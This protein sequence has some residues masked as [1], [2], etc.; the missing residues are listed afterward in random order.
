MSFISA[1][2]SSAR[3]WSKGAGATVVGDL[4][5]RRGIVQSSRLGRSNRRRGATRTAPPSLKALSRCP[6]RPIAF[7]QSRLSVPLVRPGRGRPFARPA[8]ELPGAAMGP[9]AGPT[10]EGVEAVA[11]RRW[12]SHAP[13]GHRVRPLFGGPR[14]VPPGRGACVAVWA[15][16]S[17]LLIK[18]R[19]AA[20]AK[21]RGLP[22][23][24]RRGL[25]AA[26]D[27]RTTRTRK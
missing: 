19:A 9:L 7:A 4:R 12:S 3:S 13:V 27:G 21:Q 1:P 17:A 22:N 11:L 16:R 15:V 26:A 2:A 10:V 18:A 14:A 24:L 20:P 6:D 25:R 5:I 23:V 8:L